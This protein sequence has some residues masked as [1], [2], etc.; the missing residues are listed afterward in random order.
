MMEERLRATKIDNKSGREDTHTQP[1]SMQ[2]QIHF[3]HSVW[4]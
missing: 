3:K 1:I 4:N 2:N